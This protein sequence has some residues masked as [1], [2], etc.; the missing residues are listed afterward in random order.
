MLPRVGL[1]CLFVMGITWGFADARSLV[2]SDFSTT[3][4]S[5]KFN[6]EVAEHETVVKNDRVCALCEQF[7]SQ[8]ITYLGENKTQTQIIDKL[9]HTCSE[10]PY[11]K[12]ECSRLV[13][14]YAPLFFLEIAT[15]QPETF[16]EKVNLCDE[17]LFTPPNSCD[18]C[19]IVTAEILAKLEDPE[20]QLEIIKNL[21]KLCNVV[22]N[23][24]KKCKALIFEYGPLILAKTQ[25]FLENKELCNIIHA[26]KGSNGGG[27]AESSLFEVP[28]L[29]DT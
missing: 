2:V 16:C 23:Y 27:E 6:I 25:K 21:L 22:E 17:T 29:S 12:K 4:I 9:H 10:L 14:Y 8:A 24:E 26:C 28:L 13:D 1:L 20:T 3:Q 11:Y 5:Q 18:V 7:T 15:I 19:H